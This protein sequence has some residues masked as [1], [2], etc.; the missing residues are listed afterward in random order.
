MQKKIK[1]RKGGSLTGKKP[2]K[3]ASDTAGK[4]NLS[5]DDREWVARVVASLSPLTDEE[6]EFLALIFQ[7]PA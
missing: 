4:Y 1:R 3:S 7:K 2:Q 5:D 6:R